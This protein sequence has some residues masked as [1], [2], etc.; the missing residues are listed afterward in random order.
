MPQFNL[1]RSVEVV[2]SPRVLQLEGFFDIPPS[3]RSE[4][5]WSVNLPLEEKPWHIGLIHGPSGSGKSTLAREA[6]GQN[7]IAGYDWPADRSLV[8]AFPAALGIK[9]ITGLLSSVGFSS[10]PSWLRPFSCLSTG[11]QFRATIARS[12]A[13]AQALAVV[14][15]FTSV[16]DR[17]VAQI[18]SAAIAKA[19]RRRNQK[20]V[21]VT[22]H[23]DVLDWL[24]PDW[25]C[26]MPNGE[27]TWRSL[28]RR[29]EIR[30]E[31][32]RVHR[33]VWELFEHHHYLD[34]HL[35]KAAKCF[36]GMIEGRPVVFSAA[37]HSVGKKSYW[38]EHRT[39]CLPDFQGVGIGNVMSEF[40]ASLFKATGKD[41]GSTTSNPAMIRHRARSPLWKMNRRPGLVRPD[42]NENKTVAVG[43][44][45]SRSVSRLTAG[46]T[47]V[48]P[49]R[50]EESRRFGVV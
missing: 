22:C 47:Y 44:A 14:D 30:L 16:V 28:Q 40:V 45:E 37:L 34:T 21:A 18:G 23:A 31:I 29:P 38:R 32:A 4:R 12:L 43:L 36:L 27:F 19:V 20:F 42:R 26:E 39:V 6:F 33:R 13:E 8:D 25:V 15:E 11:E 49:A 46:F 17:T 5:Q 35:H 10:P 7:L 48:G 24:Q 41:Y 9:D 1:V 3:Q 2:R 50:A